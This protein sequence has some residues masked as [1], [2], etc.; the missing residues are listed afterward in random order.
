MLGMVLEHGLLPL[1]AVVARGAGILARGALMPA[2]PPR[3]NARNFH[4]APHVV[5]S[6]LLAAAVAMA[7]MARPAPL[8]RPWLAAN[9][10]LLACIL[11]GATALRYGSTLRARVAALAGAVLV[12]AF[13]VGTASQRDPLWP[14]SIAS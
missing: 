4:I 3:L 9:S 8:V 12:V 11:L 14:L 5:D 13:I 1:G 2:G 10:G 7:V 6:L